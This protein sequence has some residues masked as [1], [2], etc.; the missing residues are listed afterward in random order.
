MKSYHFF[1]FF[2]SITSTIY[3][4]VTFLVNSVPQKT[5]EDESIYI[6]GDFEGWTGGQEKYKLSRN[7]NDYS[8]TLPDQTSIINF[9]FTKGSWA[10]VET[11]IEGNNI[12]NRTYINNQ[13][14]DTV[15]IKILNWMGAAIKKST[16]SKNVSVLSDHFKMPQLSRTRRIWI[17]LPPDYNSTKKSYPVLY[18]HDG[19]NL[20]DDATSYA[21]EWNVDETLNQL[22][23]EKGFELIVIG[24][25]HANEKRLDEY[26]PWHNSKYQAGGQGD[27]YLEFIVETLKPYIDKQYRTLVD[28]YNTGLMGSS[29]GGLISHY[30]ALKYSENFG[31]IGVF[32]PAFGFSDSSN[33]FAS[34]HSDIKEIKMYFMAGDKESQTMVSNMNNMITLMKAK[35]FDQKNIRSKVIKDGEHN[36]KLWRENFE[37]AIVW[38]YSE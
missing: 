8:I 24:I 5:F 29:M 25:D 17:Y 9:K 3:S 4:Q 16:A 23:K 37:E 15:N 10:S 26:S 33:D 14:N 32:S 13:K 12:D 21:G 2:L 31:K 18:M 35:G 6:S 27:A 36:E 22:Y 28:K 30:G 7:N 34:K 19:Q 1:I 38:L 20:F 11:D